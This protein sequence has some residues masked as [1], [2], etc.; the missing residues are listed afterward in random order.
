MMTTLCDRCYEPWTA[1]GHGQYLCPL[2]PRRDSRFPNVIPDTF[3]TPLVVEHLTPQPQTFYSRAAHR[4]WVKAHGFRI[5]DE[6]CSAPGTDK[7]RN[8]SK[9]V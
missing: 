4:E 5:R 9:W 8:V 6:H 3:A 7:N 2:E 1:E